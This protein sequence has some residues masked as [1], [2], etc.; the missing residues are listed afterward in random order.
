MQYL[1]NLGMDGPNVNKK[2]SKNLKKALDAKED[3][4][5]IDIGSCNLHAVNNCFGKAVELL[6][7]QDIDLDQFVIDLHFFFK[8]SA[9]RREDYLKMSEL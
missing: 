7:K 1:M 9:A 2:F 3:T 6:K 4:S 8:L 5:F